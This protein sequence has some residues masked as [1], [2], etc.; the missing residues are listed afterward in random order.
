[1]IRSGSDA[2]RNA[3]ETLEHDTTLAPQF[4]TFI[5]V[6]FEPMKCDTNDFGIVRLDEVDS[7]LVG[8]GTEDPKIA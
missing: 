8:R 2:D 1:M 5:A 3:S 4:V 6:Y 7:G